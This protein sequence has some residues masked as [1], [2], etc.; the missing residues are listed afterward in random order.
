MVAAVALEITRCPGAET[1]WRR[2]GVACGSAPTLCFRQVCNGIALP[3][4]LGR[5]NEET[6]DDYSD[7]D[8]VYGVGLRYLLPGLLGVFAE[9]ERFG[10][11]FETVSLGATL[12]F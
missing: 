5:Q 7:E 2:L 9:F 4:I 8:V 3:S 11:S 12:G 10:D 1:C 6:L